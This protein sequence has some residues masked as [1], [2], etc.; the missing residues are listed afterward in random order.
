MGGGGG[1][2]SSD[3][4]KDLERLAKRSKK[5]VNQLNEMCSLVL[6]VMT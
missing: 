2:F 1:Y 5:L 3:D 6:I 4:H